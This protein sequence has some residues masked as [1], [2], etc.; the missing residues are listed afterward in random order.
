MCKSAE[1]SITI[2]N[3]RRE[4]AGRGGKILRDLRQDG[5]IAVLVV[6][7]TGNLARSL[8]ANRS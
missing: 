4:P 8:E 5:N 7:G 3:R 2:K 6:G 1:L